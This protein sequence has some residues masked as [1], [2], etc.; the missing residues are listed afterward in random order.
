MIIV[1]QCAAKKQPGA[2]HL[3][4]TAGKRVVFVAEPDAA[5]ADSALLYARPD[6]PSCTGESWRQELLKYNDGSPN[7]PRDLYPAWKLYKNKT[8]GRLVDR[9]GPQKVY[10]LSAGWGLIRADFLTPNYDITFSPSA[11]GYTRRR[12]ADRYQD[13]RMLPIEADGR[14]VFFGGKDYLPL[15]SALT[16]AIRGRKTVFYNA[17]RVPEAPGCKLKRFETKRRINW[18]YECANAFLD[19]IVSVDCLQTAEPS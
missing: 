4:S 18:H 19:G 14:I 16:S 9:F 13:F 12:K 1:I 17:S 6:D 5:P 2:G 11:K 15:F 3:M 8:Y 10:I 7:N